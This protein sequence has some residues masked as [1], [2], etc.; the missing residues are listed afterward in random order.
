MISDGGRDDG[1]GGRS[2]ITGDVGGDGGDGEV[3]VGELTPLSPARIAGTGVAMATWKDGG[4]AK[5][6]SSTS[7]PRNEPPD[8]GGGV[9][10]GLSAY[11]SLSPT[12]PPVRRDD[13]SIVGVGVSGVPSS[14]L[15][16]SFDGSAGG[17]YGGG[18]T[19]IIVPGKYLGTKGTGPCIGGPSSEASV[20]NVPIDD[21]S[22]R[23][24]RYARS[25]RRARNRL[26]YSESASESARTAR[27]PTDPPTAP[28][29]VTALCVL[30]AEEVADAVAWLADGLGEVFAAP[31][32]SDNVAMGG[33]PPSVVFPVQLEALS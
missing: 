10:G 21:V 33:L 27:S 24:S 29:N 13:H 19:S 1:G 30:F 7:A 32:G 4:G 12:T 8:G 23:A 2:G 28:A 3:V 15:V 17:E 26:R 20:W 16:G 31:T 14:A 22:R 9:G 6:P 18:A 11:D 5:K 25:R